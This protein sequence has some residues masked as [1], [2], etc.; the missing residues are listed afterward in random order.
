MFQQPD[1]LG[2]LGPGFAILLADVFEPRLGLAPRRRPPLIRRQAAF[3]AAA[4]A[5][6]SAASAASAATSAA[7][8]TTLYDCASHAQHHKPNGSL[9]RPIQT[10]ALAPQRCSVCRRSRC[11]V[12]SLPCSNGCRGQ[13]RS[14]QRLWRAGRLS[15]LETRAFIHLRSYFGE[16]IASWAAARPPPRRRRTPAAPQNAALHQTATCKRLK[17]GLGTTSASASSFWD[18][19][20]RTAARECTTEHAKR[21]V[22]LDGAAGSSWSRQGQPMPP[23]HRRRPAIGEPSRARP[24]A[25][26]SRPM[27][28]S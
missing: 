11:N 28:C 14:R 20:R 21:R 9:C 2:A 12:E 4:A 22:S 8:A 24:Q 7:P 10:P 25:T 6:P 26:K 18:S 5:A 3:A 16:L 23:R 15:R 19:T 1:G 13:R 17:F 27:E